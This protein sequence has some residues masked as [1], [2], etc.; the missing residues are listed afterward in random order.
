[1]PQSQYFNFSSKTTGLVEALYKE[2]VWDGGME[3]WE[4]DLGHM[5][6]M[7]AMPI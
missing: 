6:K 1:M 2:P 3:V 5:S 4:W 7:A